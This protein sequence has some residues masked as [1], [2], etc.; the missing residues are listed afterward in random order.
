MCFKTSISR[1]PWKSFQP[2]RMQLWCK[3]SLLRLPQKNELNGFLKSWPLNSRSRDLC[4]LNFNHIEVF[5]WV[6]I[7]PTMKDV[8]VLHL[9]DFDRHT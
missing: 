3:T 1:D 7:I 4:H 6:S 2:A 5:C 9:I 8:C